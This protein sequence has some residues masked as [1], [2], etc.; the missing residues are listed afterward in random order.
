MKLATS[1][2]NNAKHQNPES[3]SQDSEGPSKIMAPPPFGLDASPIQ[4]KGLATGGSSEMEGGEQ[5]QDTQG[6]GLGSMQLKSADAATPPSTNAIQR[7]GEEEE[8]EGIQMKS[9]SPFQRMAAA[10]DEEEESIQMKSA[11]PL[12]RMGE[13][14]EEESIQMKSAAPIQRLAEED[15]ESIQMKT[16][17]PLQRNRQQQQNNNRLPTI[18]EETEE[19]LQNEMSEDEFSD[20]DSEYFDA[21]ST[22]SDSDSEYFD[23]QSQFSQESD[24][25]EVEQVNEQ[26]ANVTIP[27]AFDITTGPEKFHQYILNAVGNIFTSNTFS[28]NVFFNL[29]LGVKAD[30]LNGM[31]GV[32]GGGVFGVNL[33][34]NRQDD[35]LVRGGWSIK[36]GGQFVSDILWFIHYTREWVGKTSR[37]AVYRDMPHF[38]AACFDTMKE[39]YNMI[40]EHSRGKLNQFE[41]GDYDGEGLD[42]QGLANRPSTK[43]HGHESSVSN[44]LELGVEGVNTKATGSWGE[45]HSTSH[46]YKDQG[47]NTITK[48]SSQDVKSYSLGVEVDGVGISLGLSYTDIAN[49][50]NADNDGSYRNISVTFNNLPDIA[51]VKGGV[52]KDLQGLEAALGGTMDPKITLQL[53]AGLIAGYVKKQVSSMSAFEMNSW[54]KMKSGAT[55]EGKFGTSNSLTAEFNFIKSGDNNEFAL[56]YFRLSAGAEAKYGWD[57]SIP[58]ASL[59]G[60]ANIDVYTNGNVGAN[61]SAGVFEILG[62]NTLSYLITVYNGLVYTDGEI[63]NNFATDK[64]GR[65]TKYRSTHMPAIKQMI[66]AL[67]SPDSIPYQEAT[68]SYGLDPG[69]PLVAAAA[70]AKATGNVSSTALQHFENFL[71]R[72]FQANKADGTATA[73]DANAL[74]QDSANGR[75]PWYQAVGGSSKIFIDQANQGDA[76]LKRSQY[77]PSRQAPTRPTSI[78]DSLYQ[79]QKLDFQWVLKRRETGGVF[80]H[81]GADK[82]VNKSF[83]LAK[84]TDRPTAISKLAASFKGELDE[85]GKFNVALLNGPFA[86]TNLPQL[87][88]IYYQAKAQPTGNRGQNRNRSKDIA[89]KRASFISQIDP[90]L[91]AFAADVV[92]KQ[93]QEAGNDVRVEEGIFTDTEVLNVNQ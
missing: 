80:T 18:P 17:K 62:N 61:A 28:V 64:F 32:G 79:D 15:E 63:A 8:E 54:Q 33:T 36:Y 3:Q 1:R 88:N 22:L 56:Q 78:M 86:N 49:H 87:W 39:G 41:Y 70:E 27:G 26:E 2:D 65:W 11:S 9:A 89:A 45:S 10:D 60:V 74:E 57:A 81:G 44:T 14:E 34:L 72:N 85:P 66:M 4:A 31:F 59:Y 82:L 69:D 51:K 68:G 53:A 75:T 58:V 29:N 7:M 5:E 40:A 13:E 52:A 76:V 50:A 67:G 77:N 6:K 21:Q 48:T 47:E 25:L 55:G 83:K 23:A 46:F 93:I 30:V 92:G 38:A 19:D 37:T 24:G 35:R 43:V 90:A 12:Q 42:W 84:G 20:S 71:Y 16:E 91:E 73:G